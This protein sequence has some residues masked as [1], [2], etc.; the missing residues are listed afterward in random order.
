M[1]TTHV[2]EVEHGGARPDRQAEPMP[3]EPALDSTVALVLEGY[4][5]ISRRCRRLR[6]DV[7]RTR[8]LLQP[9]ICMMGEGAARLFYDERRFVRNGAAPRR[10]RRTLLGFGGVQGLDDAAH[11]ARKAMFMEIMNDASI[12]RLHGEYEAEWE[13][14]IE[15]WIRRDR[16]IVLMHEVER[17]LCVAACRW[18]GVPLAASEVEGRC[19]DLAAMIDGAGGIGMRFRRAAR[20]RNRCEAWVADLVDVARPAPPTAEATP[21]AEI[22]NFRGPDGRWLPRRIAAVEVL[23]LLRPIVAVGRFVAFAALALHSHPQARDRIVR[24]DEDDVLAFVHE[25]RRFYPFFPFAAAR[26]RETFVWRGLRF[27][28]GVRVLLDIYGTDHDARIWQDPERFRPERFE[29]DD[30]G[31]FAFVPQGGGDPHTGH[32]CAGESVTI[33]LMATAVHV[34]TRRIA[35]ELPAQDLG[36]DR[37]RIPTA[38][39]SGVRIRDVRWLS[40]PHTHETGWFPPGALEER[41][42]AAVMWPPA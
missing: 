36:I 4:D 2:T 10:L 31:A 18:A 35:Y 13:A 34:L 20:A 16:E 33:E 30:P 41:D 25:V 8:I 3:R 24:G 40:P 29:G 14:A 32:R 6:T 1:S 19:R 11:R 26:V 28:R 12:R 22:A 37:G 27:P 9:T 7:F 42:A 15:R 17:I 5:F 39:A 21:L 38:P 23:N